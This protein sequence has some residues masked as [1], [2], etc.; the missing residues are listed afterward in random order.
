MAAVNLPDLNCIRHFSAH[1]KGKLLLKSVEVLF[2]KDLLGFKI[3]YEI[4]SIGLGFKT[5]F[6]LQIKI[7]L[8]LRTVETDNIQHAACDYAK[9]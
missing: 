1:M 3:T 2:K 8:F 4:D 9:R 5:P 7:P 6:S